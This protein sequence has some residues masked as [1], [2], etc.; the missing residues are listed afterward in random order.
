MAGKKEGEGEFVWPNGKK[1]KG[2]WRKGQPDGIMFLEDNCGNIR[3]VE[4]QR[5]RVVKNKL[6]GDIKLE[7]NFSEN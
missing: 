4:W 7:L 6:E 2:T 3:K 1:L 5:G